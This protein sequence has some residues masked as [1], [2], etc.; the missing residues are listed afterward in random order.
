MENLYLIFPEIFISISIMLF[1]IVG[2]FKKNSSYLIYNL[3]ITSLV[4]LLAL[5]YNLNSITDTSLFNGSYKI[6]KL[7]T[8]MKLI[9]SGTIKILGK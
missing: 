2:V 6:D 1:L 8:F 9:N 7:A 4:I 5:I 3:S